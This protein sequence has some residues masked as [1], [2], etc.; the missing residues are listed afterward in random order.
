MVA[1]LLAIPIGAAL[2][3]Q[4]IVLVLIGIGFD[5]VIA[6]RRLVGGVL[7]C[8][9]RQ[10]SS[11]Q[12]D[13]AASRLQISDLPWLLFLLTPRRCTICMQRQRRMLGR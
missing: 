11:C 6:I 2:L 3:L 1:R 8:F 13:L 4:S 5:V 12:S 7:W 9:R 10:C